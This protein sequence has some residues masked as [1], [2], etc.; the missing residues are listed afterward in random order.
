[1]TSKNG[2]KIED[3]VKRSESLKQTNAKS[4]NQI[5]TLQEK[6]QTE[7]KKEFTQAELLQKHRSQI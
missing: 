3:N 1:M 2:E 4:A 7:E 5:P 6:D